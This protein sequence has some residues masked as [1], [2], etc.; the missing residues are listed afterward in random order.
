[1]TT[2]KAGEAV[3]CT[4]K[5]SAHGT[6]AKSGKRLALRDSKSWN[7]GSGRRVASDQL[8]NVGRAEVRYAGT[9]EKADRRLALRD[10]DPR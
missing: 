7:S 8:C 4:G 3:D 9:A 2:E 1:M 5:G 10:S 6:A